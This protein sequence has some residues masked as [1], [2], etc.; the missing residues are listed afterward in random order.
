M[1]IIVIDVIETIFN[2]NIMITRGDF[3]SSL[4][5]FVEYKKLVA[6]IY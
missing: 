4:F 5:D 2:K 3:K 6:V 1:E